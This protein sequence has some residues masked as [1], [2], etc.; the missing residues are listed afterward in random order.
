MIHRSDHS[1]TRSSG[2][3]STPAPQ[4]DGS[5]ATHRKPSGVP[6]LLAEMALTL[7]EQGF[8][9]LT[10]ESG[11]GKACLARQLLLMQGT[12]EE[13]ILETLLPMTESLA[14]LFA[15]NEPRM[16]QTATSEFVSPRLMRGIE[17]L[18]L[19]QQQELL[20][21]L[22]TRGET[23]VSAQTPLLLTSRRDLQAA[24]SAGQF[25]GDLYYRMSPFR[26]RL[27]PLRERTAEIPGLTRLFVRQ[28]SEQFGK[29]VRRIEDHF[30]A[31]LL[32]YPWP[33]N[34][35]ELKHVLERAVLF[36]ETGV[37]SEN[38]L[39]AD[40]FPEATDTASPQP[41]FPQNQPAASRDAIAE[42]SR[43]PRDR[44]EQAH[45][46]ATD[47]S[48]WG[49]G[50]CSEEATL[51]SSVAETERERIERALHRNLHSRTHTARELGISRVTLYNKMKKL[52]ISTRK[53]TSLR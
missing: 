41:A 6:R 24:A 5:P 14:V 22:E 48:S 19:R 4:A 52:G 16:Q 17:H 49:Q 20:R 45:Q 32:A 46:D 23:P 29:P 3:Q 40:L 50:A 53:P 2:I 44:T 18:S 42:T 34:V 38:L 10:G 12:P 8:V 51:E 25:R 47:F 36:C 26:F 27:P 39:P 9:L 37:L 43:F 28:S 31:R 35:R 13:Q 11:T 21:W 1:L 7:R 33:G 15:K 30:M